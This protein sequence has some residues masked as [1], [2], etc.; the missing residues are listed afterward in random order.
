[1]KDILIESREY[2]LDT[3]LTFGT[4]DLSLVEDIH[5]ELIN[6]M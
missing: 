5:N 2:T 6:K 1:M 4:L 3:Y